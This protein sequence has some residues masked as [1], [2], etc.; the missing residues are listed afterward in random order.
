[1][2]ITRLTY[3]N[4]ILTILKVVYQPLKAILKSNLNISF[5]PTIILNHK[6]CSIHLFK[7]INLSIN[8]NFI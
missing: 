6:F 5:D 4:G 3:S 2:L 7:I 1:M 8:Y